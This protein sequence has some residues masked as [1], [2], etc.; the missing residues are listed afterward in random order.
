MKKS[1][2]FIKINEAAINR[3]EVSIFYWCEDS[4]EINIR[5]KSGDEHT[6]CFANKNELKKGVWNLEL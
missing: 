3:N 2:N 5:M 1:T 4:L 6:F